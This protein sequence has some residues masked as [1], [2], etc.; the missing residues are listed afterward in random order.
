M[1]FQIKI[2]KIWVKKCLGHLIKFQFLWK[3]M[4]SPEKVNKLNFFEFIGTL[5][6]F[7]VHLCIY[8]TRRR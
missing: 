2:D 7:N 3:A 8:K 1:Q 6:N 5:N 4:I